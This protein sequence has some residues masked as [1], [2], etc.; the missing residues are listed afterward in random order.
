MKDFIDYESDTPIYQQV[1]QHI[2]MEIENGS[3]KPGERLPTVRALAQMNKIAP[4]TVKLA[5]DTL[6]AS[7][8]V[9]KAQGRGTFVKAADVPVDRS[10]K[11]Q[12]LAA[13]DEMLDRLQELGFSRWETSIFLDLK[14]REREE[15]EPTV[16]VG[17]VD[18]SPEARSVIV[19]Q[20]S[21]LPHVDAYEFPLERVTETE[22]RFNPGTDL[23]IT[24]STHAQDV[25]DKLL[26]GYKLLPVV[27]MVSSDTIMELARISADSQ[28]GIICASERFQRIII[29]ACEQYGIR[30]EQIHTT[31]FGT[32]DEMRTFLEQIDTLILPCNYYR[33]CSWQEQ[34]S[35]QQYLL[36]GRYIEYRYQVDK[37]SMMHLQQAIEREYEQME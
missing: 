15:Y 7:G 18:C 37:G 35:L 14:M 33:L 23:V 9:E 16:K 6:A 1:V 8:L 31:R 11:E 26:P 13:I 5:Y 29:K 36:E 22:E 34:K 32:D 27:M 3:L 25:G 19:D 12:A 21:A 24:T 4:G 17:I 2:E 10:K 20:I 28:V 30:A